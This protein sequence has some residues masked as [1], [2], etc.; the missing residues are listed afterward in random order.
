MNTGGRLRK[1]APMEVE[2]ALWLVSVWLVAV[3]FV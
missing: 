3:S 2:A 1:C